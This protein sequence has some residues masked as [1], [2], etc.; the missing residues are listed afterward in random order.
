MDTVTDQFVVRGVSRLL[1]VFAQGLVLLFELSAPFLREGEVGLHC[2]E[3]P[4]EKLCLGG[5]GIRHLKERTSFKFIYSL[6]AM[7]EGTNL[8]FPLRSHLLRSL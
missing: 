1:A 3:L 2:L 7:N 5:Y 6:L 4:Q 8:G